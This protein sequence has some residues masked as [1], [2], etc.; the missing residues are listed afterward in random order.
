MKT[1]IKWIIA[2]A[3][4]AVLVLL[5]RCFAFSSFYIP[6]GSVDKA[7]YEGEGILVNKWSYG[8]RAPLPSLFGYHRWNEKP[9]NNGDI[10]VFNNPAN[11]RDELEF[12]ETFIGH[13]AGG[14]GDTLMVDSLFNVQT[15][16]QLSSFAAMAYYLYPDSLEEKIDSLMADLHI[17]AG[18][19]FAEDSLHNVRVF[20]RKEHRQLVKAMDCDNCLVPLEA[21]RQFTKPLIVPGKGVTVSVYPWNRTLLRNTIL[22][23]EDKDAAIKNDTLFV[24]GMPVERYTFD[25]DY[26]WM[27]TIDSTQM[28]DSRLFGFVP[29][30]YLIGRAAIVW[31]SKD[32]KA[33]WYKGYRTD[34]FFHRLDR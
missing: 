17:P 14:P 18:T 7:F 4:A 22:L 24:N 33:S 28:A 31:F 20:T 21:N 16:E 30:E 2:I 34:R 3:G 1:C 8:L 27:T 32:P 15:A 9:V 12:K 5:L 10:V 25:K 26:Y 19:C 29:Q 23:H 6:Q 13:C 11:V